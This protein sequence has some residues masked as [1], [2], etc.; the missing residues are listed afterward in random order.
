M[1]KDDIGFYDAEL[2]IRGK[3]ISLKHRVEVTG[4]HIKLYSPNGTFIEANRHRYTVG[5]ISI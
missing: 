4:K 5:K 3:L 2:I 1:T